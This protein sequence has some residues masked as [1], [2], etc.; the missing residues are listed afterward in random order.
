MKKRNKLS[1]QGN[2]FHLIAVAGATLWQYCKDTNKNERVFA[3][4]M[5]GLSKLIDSP[6]KCEAICSDKMLLIGC[7]EESLI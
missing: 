6:E 2:E 1:F 3:K 7:F 5:K 4:G